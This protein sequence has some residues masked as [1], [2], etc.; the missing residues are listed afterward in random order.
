MSAM[1]VVAHGHVTPQS[2]AGA[3]RHET[4]SIDSDLPVRVTSLDERLA[5]SY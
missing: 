5:D 4:Q 1:W 2:F 3:F